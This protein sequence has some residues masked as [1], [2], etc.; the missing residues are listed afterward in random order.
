MYYHPGKM[1]T[2]SRAFNRVRVLV[3]AEKQLNFAFDLPGLVAASEAPFPYDNR[4][5]RN[6]LLQNGQ[7]QGAK[8]L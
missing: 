3:L 7:K 1:K 4:G 8:A 6:N 2:Y 5:L